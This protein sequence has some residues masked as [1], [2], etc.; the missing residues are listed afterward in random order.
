MMD[1]RAVRSLLL[2]GAI[3]GTIILAAVA[4]PILALPDPIKME[5]A[6]RLTPPVSGH[7][8]GRDEYGRDVLS[9]LLWGARWPTWRSRSWDAPL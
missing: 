4:A 8:L 2:P 9:R 7:F 1:R 3:V 5:V 6:A